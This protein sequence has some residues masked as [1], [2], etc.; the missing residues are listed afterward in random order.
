MALSAAIVFEARAS[1]GN[2]NWGG[3]F[4]AGATGTDRSQ[5]N[6][7]QVAIDNA[8]ITTSITANVITFT[9]YT[10][11]SADVGN[12]VQMLTG[13]NVTAGF[14]EITAQTSTTW[15][16]TGTASLPT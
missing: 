13:T 14:Y 2:D 6:S 15:T 9:G 4:K 7:A 11:T 8:T 3:G 1:T 12:V 5:Q 10:P 16:V